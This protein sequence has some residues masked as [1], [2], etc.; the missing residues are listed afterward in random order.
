LKTLLDRV[1][2]FIRLHDLAGPDT[3]MLAAVSGGS[4]SVALAHLLH[5]LDAAGIVRLIGF[6]HVNHMLRPTAERDER[7]AVA[8]A[9][10]LGRAIHVARVD[11]GS[12]ARA[13]QQSIE[14]AAHTARYAAF[15]H[16]RIELGA[17]RVALGH[18]RDDQAETYLLR[19]IR[20]AGPRGLAGMHPRNGWIIRPLLDVR[21]HELRGWLAAR[22]IPFIEDESNEDTRIPRNRVRAELIPLLQE[23]FNPRIV[24]ALAAEAELAR[25]TLSWTDEMVA[26]FADQSVQPSGRTLDIGSLLAAPLALRRAVLWRVMTDLAPGRTVGFEH[27]VSA[28]ALLDAAGPKSCDAPGQHLER[29]GSCLVLTSRAGQQEGRPLRHGGRGRLPSHGGLAENLFEHRLSIPGEVLVTEAGWSISA[30]VV[31]AGASPDP[32]KEVQRAHRIEGAVTGNGMAAL[33]RGDCCQQSLVVRN[34]RPGDR[35]HPAGLGGRKKLQDFFVDRKIARD[36]RDRVPIVTVSEDDSDRIVW[37][38]GHRID[39]AFRV[40]DPGQGMLLLKLKA[41]GGSA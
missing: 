9:E 6:V 12:Q 18:T 14:R 41:L 15:E 21:R 23:R 35:F 32:V 16:A 5:E 10:T 20:G 29:I 27:V 39:E 38:A 25:E 2:E 13:E 31:A 4:D 26:R 34:R 1:R 17:E 3:G 30:E 36:D 8:V 22:E 11:V 28:L 33:V 24:E 19:L 7:Q 40:T 37:V